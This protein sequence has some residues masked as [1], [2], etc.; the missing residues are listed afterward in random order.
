MRAIGDCFFVH[1]GI[2][3]S[4]YL[5]KVSIMIRS[6]GL[7]K[8]ESN[9]TRNLDAKVT[10]GDWERM[11]FNIYILDRF[12][13][14]NLLDNLA[15]SSEENISYP[16]F[17]NRDGLKTFF[18]KHLFYLVNDEI[19]KKECVEKAMYHFNQNGIL[20][21]THYTAKESL[22]GLCVKGAKQPIV[23]KIYFTPD[24]KGVIIEEELSFIL[25]HNYHPPKTGVN[26]HGKINSRYLFTHEHIELMSVHAD[27]PSRTVD[28]WFEWP[29]FIQDLVNYMRSLFGYAAVDFEPTNNP[30]L[31]K[32]GLD[33]ALDDD[34]ALD[35]TNFTF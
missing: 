30:Y 24:S 23:Q 15:P 11:G 31:I 2:I 18:D 8:Y 22:W 13:Q 5:H 33:Q 14:F 1:I 29:K 6:S 10:I 34:L 7:F 20:W 28:E 26:Y 32:L 25:D 27:F 21:A 4:K 9:N 19:K 17:N 35:E 12:N 16:R 3:V